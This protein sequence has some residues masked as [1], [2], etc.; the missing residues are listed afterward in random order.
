MTRSAFA[1]NLH[2]VQAQ[3]TRFLEPPGCRKR[4]RTFNRAAGEGVPH[5]INLRMAGC[6]RPDDQ[7][8]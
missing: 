6:P 4:G 2:P 7:E 1:G 5:V 3:L 8:T